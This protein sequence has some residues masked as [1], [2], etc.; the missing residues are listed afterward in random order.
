[1]FG[2]KHDQQLDH[3]ISEIRAQD[4]P[5]A[6]LEDS[7]RRVW[8]R[9]E[10]A[11]ATIPASEAAGGCATIRAYLSLLRR[12][13][14][15]PARRLIVEDHLRECPSCRAYAAG[16]PDPVAAAENWRLPRPAGNASAW[17]LARYVWAAAAVVLLAVAPWIGVH[18]LAVPAG[19]RAQ[20]ESIAGRVYLVSSVNE[21]PLKAGEQIGQGEMVRTASDSHAILRLLDGSRVEMNQRTELSVAAG[22]FRNTTIHLDEGDIIVQARHRNT[23]RLYVRTPD[24]TVSDTGTIFSIESG[25]KG[26][27]VGVVEGT[28]SVGH[29]GKKSVLHAG[30]SVSTAQSMNTVPV[31]GQIAWSENRQQYLALLD[32]FSRLGHRFE[33]IPSPQPRYQSQILPLVPE[34]SVLYLSVPNLGNMFAQGDRIFRNE[35]QRSPVLRDWWTRVTTPQ[36]DASLEQA[37]GKIE[38]ASEYLGDEMVLVSGLDGKDGPVLLAPIKNPGLA[39]FLQQQVSS[40][41]GGDS[42][43]PVRIVDE[44]S[45]ASVSPARKEL[46]ALVRPDLLVVGTLEAVLHMNTA[47]AHGPSGFVNTDFGKQVQSVYNQGAQVLFAADLQHI[48]A[49]AQQTEQAKSGSGAEATGN[50][51]LDTLGFGDMKYLIATHGDASSQT[52]NRA[53]LG[54]ERER[55]GLASWL[56]APS[57]MGSLDFVSANASEAVSVVTKE[58]AKMFDDVARMVQQHN[59]TNVSAELEQEEDQIGMG[60][61]NNLAGALGGE[62]TFALD[63]PILPKPAWKLIAEVNEPTVL[64]QSISTLVQLTGQHVMISGRPA[65]AI[66]QQQSGDRTFYRITFAQA[67]DLAEIDYTFADGYLV[68]GSSRAVVLNALDTRANGDSLASSGSFRSLLPRD[69][70]ANF[71]ALMYWNLGP[72]VRSLVAQ[73]GSADQGIL[74]HFAADAKPAVIC[75]YGGTN[76]IELASTTNLLDLQ[77]DTLSLLGL[78]KQGVPG[79]SRGSNP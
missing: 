5:P 15:S 2:E 40:L 56:G 20:I 9:L 38:T 28:V 54:F 69:S 25:T 55:G 75:A 65:V 8:Q 12:R 4:I 11:S 72:V 7:A 27:R 30:Q 63:G 10:A 58:P 77:P 24:C 41:G 74:Q 1:M 76:T 59:Q 66:E 60:F 35:L 79:T 62:M 33:Q 51:V 57:P 14:L 73:F 3:L 71:S 78:L 37:I 21:S 53:M 70:Y 61:R 32:E 34:N 23:G 17:S 44:K 13:E 6:A 19:S 46:I 49:H 26:S 18:Y 43:P 39:D 31:S 68:A 29:D 64:Q 45:L 67:Q 50:S 22:F 16:A 52:E 42:Q 36:Q 48:M 47:L